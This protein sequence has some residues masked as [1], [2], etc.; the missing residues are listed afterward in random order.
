M[1]RKSNI[2]NSQIT[3]VVLAGGKATRM[4]GIDKGL[5]ELNGIPMCKVVIDQLDPQVAEVLVN[6]NRNIEVYEGFGCAG[7]T[8]SDAGISR[9]SCGTFQCDECGNNTMGCDSSM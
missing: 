4:G 5:V 3:G 7:S 2:E 1:N 6:A 8:G 9:P